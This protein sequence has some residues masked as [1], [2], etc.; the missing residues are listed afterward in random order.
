MDELWPLP[1]ERRVYPGLQ[2]QRADIIAHGALILERC[3]TVLDRP[4]VCVCTGD[5]LKGYLAYKGVE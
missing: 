5:N 3:L 1:A 2:P 4:K